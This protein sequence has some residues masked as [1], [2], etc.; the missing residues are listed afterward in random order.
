MYLLI[1]VKESE[2][3]LKEHEHMNNCEKFQVS[4]NSHFSENKTANAS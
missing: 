3:H 2:G 1:F 4:D